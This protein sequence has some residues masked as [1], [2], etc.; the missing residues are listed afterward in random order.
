MSAD[1][2]VRN[3]PLAPAATTSG[4]L[5]PTDDSAPTALPGAVKA[6]VSGVQEAISNMDADDID[7]SLNASSDGTKSSA[8][9]RLRAYRRREKILDLSGES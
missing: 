3:L 7:V 9:F 1:T 8:S 2:T 5:K 4:A 6:I